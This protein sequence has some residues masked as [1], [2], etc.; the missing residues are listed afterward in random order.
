[1]A[2]DWN[3]LKSIQKEHLS[4]LVDRFNLQEI[5]AVDLTLF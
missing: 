5:Y 1:M 4:S 2:I 3:L